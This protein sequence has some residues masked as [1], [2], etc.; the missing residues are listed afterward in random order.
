[1][2]LKGEQQ[3]E[4]NPE[5]IWELLQD[6]ETLASIMPGCEELIQNGEDQYKGVIKAKIGPVSSTYN[7]GFK[8]EDKDPP[9]SYRL[10]VEGQGPGG[11]VKGDVKIELAGN[12]AGTMLHYSGTA[13]VGGKIASIGQ[14]LVESGAKI[15]I[16]QGFKA[17][18]KEV[19][20][21]VSEA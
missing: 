19:S 10:L 4:G 17:L 1:M 12:D 20:K 18:K 2:D 13:N 15:I 14:R 5:Q 16:K 6:P 7:A 21:K 9:A 11:F 3:L 8:I